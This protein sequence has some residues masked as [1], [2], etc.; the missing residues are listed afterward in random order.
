MSGYVLFCHGIVN[1]TETLDAEKRHN[2]RIVSIGT[3]GQLTKFCKSEVLLKFFLQFY[4]VT[5]L[6]E[7][8][9]LLV[10]LGD[11]Y[12]LFD[13]TK[14]TAKYRFQIKCLFVLN[15]HDLMLSPQNRLRAY[16]EDETILDMH[17]SNFPEETAMA[18]FKLSTEFLRPELLNSFQFPQKEGKSIF[19]NPSTNTSQLVYNEK[20]NFDL[21]LVFKTSIH[22]ELSQYYVDIRSNTTDPQFR[23]ITFVQPMGIYKMLDVTSQMSS[24]KLIDSLSKYRAGFILSQVLDTIKSLE[25]SGDPIYLFLNPCKKLSSTV[26]FSSEPMEK[27]VQSLGQILVTQG[28]DVGTVEEQGKKALA[29]MNK[30][31]TAKPLPPLGTKK[32]YQDQLVKLEQ[33]RVGLQTQL[34]QIDHYLQLNHQWFSEAPLVNRGPI[35]AEIA[36]TIAKKQHLQQQLQQLKRLQQQHKKIIKQHGLQMTD[37]S[38]ALDQLQDQG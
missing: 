23:N 38:K 29:R 1:S 3:E 31:F 8:Y 14:S 30:Q 37:L 15:E 22:P 2:I 10:F 12:L 18:R 33:T 9:N 19:I 32:Q 25:P 28:R 7:L 20:V 34:S 16:G 13:P 5:F 4:G 36:Q 26:A 24:M 6:I 21:L 11:N 27:L 17:L 35:S